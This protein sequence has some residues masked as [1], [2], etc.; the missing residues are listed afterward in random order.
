[1]T[2][3]LASVLLAAAAAGA[4]PAPACDDPFTQIE[5]NLCSYREYQAADAE[6]NAEWD[7]TAD[8]LKSGDEQARAA[9]GEGGS[10]ARLLY[11][12]RKWLAFR[13]AH[14]LAMTGRREEGGTIWPLLHNS[15]MAEATNARIE[16]LRAL[17]EMNQ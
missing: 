4:A 14:C 12:Q 8:R 9:G 10:F 2:P 17:R 11:A 5:A 3:A 13:D 1:M 7:R 15:C 6:L 16:Q